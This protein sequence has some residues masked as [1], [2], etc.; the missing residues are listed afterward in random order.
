VKLAAPADAARWWPARP[1]GGGQRAALDALEKAQIKAFERD[2]PVESL[3]H[4]RAW[5]I[6]QAVLAH[7]DAQGEALRDTTLVATG[8]F[9][10]G[11]MHPR[12][13]VDLL[14]LVPEGADEARSAAVERFVAALWDDGL[15]V[16]HAVRDVAEAATAARGDI[17]VMSSLLDARWLAGPPAALAALRDATGPDAMWSPDDFAAAKLAEQHARH[18]RY[19]DTAYNL[20]PNLKEGP[21]G[22]RELAMPLWIAQRQLGLGTLEALRDAQ[23][24]GAEEY[25]ALIAARR[26]LWRIRFALHA[27]SRKA[28]E[29]LL[30]EHQRELAKRFG[31]RDEHAGNLAVEQF[32]Q[33]YFRAAMAIERLSERVLQ[34]LEEIR[35]AARGAIAR[36]ALDADFDDVAGFLD[37][38]DAGLFE[39]D[40][41]AILRAFRLLLEH[42]RLHG[43]RSTLLR[44]LD[45]VLPGLDEGFRRNARVNAEFLALLQSRGDVP[46]ALRR[47]SR[48]GVLG[49]YLPAFGHVAGRMQYDLFHAYTV[50]QHTLFVLRNLHRFGE[51]E[52]ADEFPLA[53]EL[54]ARLRKPELL[55]LA[56][57]FHDIAKGR[58]G[59]HSELG[60]QDARVF[61]AQL[62]LP[63]ADAD[64]VAWLVREH[65]LMSVTA[66]KQDI[67]DPAVVHRFAER[68]GDRERLDYL[69]LLTVGDI[70]GTSPKLWNSWKDRLL[71]DLH[72]ATR[73][74]LRRGLAKPVHASER[75]AETKAAAQSALLATGEDAAR[76]AAL[77]QEFPED[78]FVRYSA[79]QVAWLTRTLLAAPPGDA[80]LVAIR[81]ARDGGSSEVF[82]H[83]R[84]RDG[85]FATITAVLD[86]FSINVLDARV[87]DSHAGRVLDTFR[88]LDTDG[89]PL[90]DADRAARLRETLERELARPEL[91]LKPA[92][93]APRRLQ[94]QFHVPARIEFSP[95]ADG[96]RTQLALVCADRP[97]LLAQVAQ[98]LRECGL[99][100]HDARIATF[101]ERA[102]DFFQIT[103]A[104][105]APL[106]AAQQEAVRA[107]LLRRVADAAPAT[108]T[109]TA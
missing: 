53:H 97:G 64:L 56:G 54:H 81:E 89:Q 79:D 26:T 109:G 30:F 100:V 71:A 91:E 83:A 58:G 20:E 68:V 69:Y 37:L 4:A 108:N 16:G 32:M 98:A 105:D 41:A 52:A 33:G 48:Y 10:R 80:P 74:A 25:E 50:D 66:Q 40:P 21:G 88:V 15:K 31:L 104:R 92:Q 62:G 44:R 11:E 55:L 102:E 84:D 57:L 85:V 106:D 28:E 5:A 67:A 17:T 12:S 86:R 9:G 63:P 13:D 2:V 72:Q 94:R 6:E 29:R 82:V 22:L 60:E 75:I 78:S 38:R 7:W 1:A 24:L 65:L 23:L 59:D 43:F 51:P 90:R 76:I 49:R 77:W 46:E 96:A 18:A 27:S 19:N 103:D 35:A 47:M 14:V 45:A 34:R 73:Y 99:R 70:R 36:T 101:G 93:R 3:V 42:P 107:A 39:R 61:C 8:G 87:V 95:T